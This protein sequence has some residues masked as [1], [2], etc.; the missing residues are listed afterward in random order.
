MYFFD[1]GNPEAFVLFVCNFKMTN[2][3]SGTLEAGSKVQYLRIPVCGEALH[4]FYSL[5]ADMESVEPLTVENI[6]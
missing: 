3:A 2:A 5:S 1:N 6:I 4:K